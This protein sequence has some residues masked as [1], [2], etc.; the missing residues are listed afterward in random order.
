LVRAGNSRWPIPGSTTTFFF[1]L[2]VVAVAPVAV[3]A[4]RRTPLPVVA[5]PQDFRPNA[6]PRPL[7]LLVVVVHAEYVEHFL[8]VQTLFVEA[9]FK[10]DLVDAAHTGKRSRE[11]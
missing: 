3:A 1:V 11:G 5:F 10:G 4:G 8:L 9:N 6:A 2:V 7:V